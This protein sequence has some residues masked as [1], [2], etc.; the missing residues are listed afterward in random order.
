MSHNSQSKFVQKSENKVEIKYL[1]ENNSD[2]T[3]IARIIE[4]ENVERHKIQKNEVCKDSVEIIAL[5]DDTEHGS[6]IEILG[7][8][9]YMKMDSNNVHTSDGDYDSNG[10]SDD[11]MSDASDEND[12]NATKLAPKPVGLGIK[13]VDTKVNLREL[14]NSP[15]K[16]SKSEIEFYRKY[17]N[18][19]KRKAGITL[20]IKNCQRIRE[21]IIIALNELNNNSE[22]KNSEGFFRRFDELNKNK[23]EINTIINRFE[24]EMERIQYSEK[25]KKMESMIIKSK[26][27]QEQKIKELTY[28]KLGKIVIKQTQKATKMK[29]RQFLLNKCKGKKYL[30]QKVLKRSCY[31]K[32]KNVNTQIINFETN[33]PKK[34]KKNRYKRKKH[35]DHPRLPPNV[36]IHPH[37]GPIIEPMINPKLRGYNRQFYRGPPRHIRH[38]TRNKYYKKY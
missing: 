20:M 8:G 17:K 31:N 16:L 23:N 5:N 27:I 10:E 22:N 24:H 12:E 33:K 14:M 7:N 2:S 35:Y 13:N 11:D 3:K 1:K 4:T 34:I 28:K 36:H 32:I 25:S 18:I 6:D 19:E 21:D 30:S 38:Y 29:F 15:K 26:A 9:L 37:F